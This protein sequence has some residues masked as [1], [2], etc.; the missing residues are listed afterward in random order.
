[1]HIERISFSDEPEKIT[2]STVDCLW[3]LLAGRE[4]PSPL[5]SP[6]LQWV[7]WKLHGIISRFLLREKKGEPVATF[8]PTMRKL[9]FPF[10]ALES[11][12]HTDW[13]SFHRNCEGMKMKEV[14]LF[15]EDGARV[16]SLEKEFRRQSGVEFPQRIIF[17]SDHTMEKG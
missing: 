12:D 13:K 6:A 10:V 9:A 1:M 4:T 8:V 15:C 14:L 2:A 11:L 7:D 17:G 3:V 16:S 5:S